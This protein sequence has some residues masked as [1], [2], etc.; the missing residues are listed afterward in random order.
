MEPGLL[1]EMT[2]SNAGADKV[3]GDPGTSHCARRLRNVQRMMG[4]AKEPV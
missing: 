4:V 1:E 2:D 3:N